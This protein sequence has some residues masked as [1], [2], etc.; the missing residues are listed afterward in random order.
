MNSRDLLGFRPVNETS[1][2]LVKSIYR[3]KLGNAEYDAAI[4][5]H[6]S[7]TVY[8]AGSEHPIFNHDEIYRVVR[9]FKILLE[10][11]RAYNEKV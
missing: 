11:E 5:E 9:E 3:I 10:K 2:K 6:D 7:I 4:D 8:H 1:M